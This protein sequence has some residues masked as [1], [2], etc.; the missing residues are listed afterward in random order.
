MVVVCLACN[1]TDLKIV[2]AKA[3]EY[4]VDLLG[5]ELPPFNLCHCQ[6][7]G[8]A[9]FDYRYSDEEVQK[10][11]KDYR[12]EVY[13]QTRNKYDRLY[14]KRVNELIGSSPV[15][16]KNRKDLVN[17]VLSEYV[18]GQKAK[19]L[20]Y[21]GDMGQYI[22]S[23]FDEA[24][25]YVFE[26][27]GKDS[28]KGVKLIGDYACLINEKP[29]THIMC[30]HVLEHFSDIDSEII[31]VRNLGDDATVFYFEVPFDLP[32]FGS[33]LDNVQ[34]LFNPAYKKLD[35]IKTFIE[36]RKDKTPKM[37]EHINYFTPVSLEKVLE[38]NGFKV[39]E[40]S[41]VKI[42]CGYRKGKIIYAVCKLDS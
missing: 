26:I 18:D 38:R 2:K 34:F 5:A 41:D 19:V 32:F 7:C 15:Q 4:I 1:G 20:D 11:Y 17:N 36:R 10:I 22:P 29:F 39:L 27:S 14:T 6:A 8:F 21:G 42:D 33:M 9:F 3:S 25:K 30:S 31:R 12:G 24:D 37:N 13:Q 28:V 23:L 16:L 40:K 35:L